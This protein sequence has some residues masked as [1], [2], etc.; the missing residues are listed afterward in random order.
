MTR[1]TVAVISLYYLFLPLA[2]FL[3]SWVKF[4]IGI[5]L[6]LLL[7]IAPLFMLKD[8]RGETVTG[9]LRQE[10]VVF[11]VLLIWVVLSGIGGYVWQNRWD[12]FFRNAVFMDLVERP[13][14][15]Q[16]D[17]NALVYYLGFWLPSALVAKLT[18]SLE[19]GYFMQLIY[20]F[21][22]IYLAFRLTIDKIGSI[23]LR[24][25]LPF[26][27]FSGVD[28][29]YYLLFNE[30]VPRN[31]HIELWNGM[32]FWEGN[33]TL[34]NWVY[35]QA[36]PSWVSTMLI[37]DYGKERGGACHYIVFSHDFRSIFSHRAFPACLVLRVLPA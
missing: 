28:I 33:T 3:C 19:A 22:G 17:G 23:R 34:L 14:P 27:L 5:P 6:T 18:H 11:L 13:W 20:G 16:S 4:W 7:G 36:I 21:I 25:L 29:V 2:I 9:S 37:L 30:H 15:V 12:H 1:R 26:M 8:V 35:N 32:A 24:Y 31:F 10:T